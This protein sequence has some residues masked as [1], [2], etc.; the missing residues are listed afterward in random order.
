MRRW[1]LLGG[2]AAALVLLFGAIAIVRPY[3]SE[4]RD[5]PAS[6]PQPPSVVAIEL[7]RMEPG[8]AACLHDAVMDTHS[9]RALFQVETYGKRTVPLR[10]SLTGRGYGATVRVPASSYTNESIVNVPVP[11]PRRDVFVRA[12]FTNLGTRPAAMFATTTAEPGPVSA[13]LD[14]QPVA[15]NPWLAFYEAKPTSIIHRLPT[16]VARM[17]AFRPPFIGGWLLWPLG[18]LFAL[19]VPVAVV[20]A[21]TRALS[22]DEAEDAAR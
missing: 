19:G 2:L 5:Y 11:T 16:S 6:I 17:G 20:A 15:T 9:Q 18:V 10:L 21:F 13:T 14:G 7:V 8:Q 4:E 3:L 12:C 22:E 1:A